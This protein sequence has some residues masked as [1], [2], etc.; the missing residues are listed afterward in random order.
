MICSLSQFSGARYWWKM[1]SPNTNLL[2]YDQTKLWA[3]WR[4]FACCEWTRVWI[5]ADLRKSYL[6]QVNPLYTSNFIEVYL[7]KCTTLHFLNT[8][9]LGPLDILYLFICFAKVSQTWQKQLEKPLCR[10]DNKKLSPTFAVTNSLSSTWYDLWHR[11][12]I[13][14]PKYSRLIIRDV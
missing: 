1:P 11:Y 12:E 14:V 10:P 6:T 7:N 13:L 2:Q 4:C 5:V 9:D 3:L 8:M